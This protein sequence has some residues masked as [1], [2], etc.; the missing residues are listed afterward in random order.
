MM[1]GK[2]FAILRVQRLKTRG[3]LDAATRHG[4]RQD[5]GQHFDPDRTPFNRHWGAGPVVGP[6][7]WAEGVACAI[8]RLGAQCRKGAPLAAEFFVGASPL[9]FDPLGDEDAYFDMDRVMA[10]A[11]A[12]MAAFYERFG[13]AVVAGRL[14][15]DEGSPHMAICVVPVYTKATRHTQTTVVSYRKVFGGNTKQEARNKMIALQDWYADKMA[16]LGLSRGIR[17]AVT[18]RTHLSHNQYAR[19]RRQEDEARA[20]ALRQA[21]ERE[22]ELADRLAQVEV[23]LAQAAQYTTVANE[24][25]RQATRILLQAVKARAFVQRTAEALAA[26]DP[27]A[28]ITRVMAAKAEVFSRWEQGVDQLTRDLDA[29]ETPD[30]PSPK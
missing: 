2:T 16:P 4:R 3:D 19:K 15:L 10:W 23:E 12:T 25:A 7:D 20:L 18:G 8:R 13:E 17:K 6:V 1:T 29:I 9:Y 5:S 24:K 30:R 26:Y 14:D 21:Q 22:A 28:E 11:D 27:D